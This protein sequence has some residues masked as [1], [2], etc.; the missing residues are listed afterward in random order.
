M[1]TALENLGK[2]DS[3]MAVER[4]ENWLLDKNTPEYNK[5]AGL[6][7]MLQKYGHLTTKR[8]MYPYR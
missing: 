6:L 1:E 8:A 2:I 4:I 3:W 7:F 5:E